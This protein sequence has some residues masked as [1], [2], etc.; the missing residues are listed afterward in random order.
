MPIVYLPGLSL[1]D[2]G[3]RVNSSLTDVNNTLDAY[4]FKHLKSKIAVLLKEHDALDSEYRGLRVQLFGLKRKTVRVL[5]EA[6][7]AGRLSGR[8]KDVGALRR[9]LSG[10]TLDDLEGVEDD[11]LISKTKNESLRGD[12]MDTNE[13]QRLWLLQLADLNLEKRELQLKLR[14]KEH[15]FSKIETAGNEEF[16]NLKAILQGNL[17]KEKDIIYLIEKAK[18]GKVSYSR[19]IWGIE[20]EN[21]QLK[22]NIRELKKELDFKARES[23]NLEDKKLFAGRSYKNILLKKEREKIELQEKVKNLETVYHSLSTTVRTSLL[24]SKNKQ[25]MMGEI[26]RI[27]KENQALRRKIADLQD[28]NKE[29]QY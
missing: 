20:Q 26:I 28:K 19:Q 4:E 29:E 16:D 5:K 7:K 24:S 25:K 6:K 9:V 18:E 14:E 21:L 3:R 11:F 2:G 1:A 17:A 15:L 22:S 10:I 13:Q 12:L 27:D 8:A 23:N